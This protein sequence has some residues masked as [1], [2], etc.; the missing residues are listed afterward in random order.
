MSRNPYFGENRK[1]AKRVMLQDRR[2]I[3]RMRGVNDSLDAEF[4][5]TGDSVG[6]VPHVFRSGYRYGKRLTKT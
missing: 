3:L 5:K 1:R 4:G 2:D 6:Y